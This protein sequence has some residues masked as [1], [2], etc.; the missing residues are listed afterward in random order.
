MTEAKIANLIYQ[1]ESGKA[2]TDKERVLNFIMHNPNTTIWNIH[3]SLNIL[4]HAVS[5]RLSS[6]MD[7][8]IVRETGSITIASNNRTFSTL[9]FVNDPHFRQQ[10]RDAKEQEK[11]DKACRILLENFGHKLSTMTKV[12]LKQIM[13]P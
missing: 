7:D 13:T 1:V 8:G 12:N 3:L 10:L 5:A 6:L 2:T 4:L 11:L 9:Q